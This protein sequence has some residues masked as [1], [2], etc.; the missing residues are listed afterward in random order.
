MVIK[1]S[2]RIRKASL[3]DF[4]DAL[5]AH[6]SRTIVNVPKLHEHE[7]TNKIYGTMAKRNSEKS[8]FIEYSQIEYC[9]VTIH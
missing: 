8:A 4:T 9:N 5:S 7:S 1:F 3:I 6:C 2:R